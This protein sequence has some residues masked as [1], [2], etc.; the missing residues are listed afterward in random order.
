MTQ[1]ANLTAAFARRFLGPRAAFA[2]AYRGQRIPW[3]TNITPPELVR[4][5]EG[6]GPEHLPPGRALD[7]GCGT[8]TNSL[9]LA[10]HGWQVTGIDFIAAAIAQARAKQAH[11]GT[12]PGTVPG[13]VDWRQGDVTRLDALALRPGYDLIFDLGCFHGIPIAGRTSYAAGVT[14]LAAPDATLLLYAFG[15]ATGGGGLGAAGLTRDELATVFAPAWR[16]ARVEDGTGP[17][18][19]PSA[20]YWLRHAT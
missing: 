17:A 1:L 2:L 15:P 13:A 14:R 19:R 20:W 3:D 8:G 12:V 4:V 10:R 11:A 6:T 16:I 18:G 9:Y 7:L 5:V